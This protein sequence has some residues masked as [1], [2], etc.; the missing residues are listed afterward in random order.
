M[1]ISHTFDCP[2]YIVFT[3]APFFRVNLLKMDQR[4]I[5]KKARQLLHRNC[6]ISTLVSCSLVTSASKFLDFTSG[7]RTRILEGPNKSLCI[8]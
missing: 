1:Y 8:E 3:T 2:V 4:V 6:K 7:L 5:W